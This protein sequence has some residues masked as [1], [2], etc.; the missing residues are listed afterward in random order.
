M[1]E[2]NERAQQAERQ[3]DGLAAAGDHDAAAEL[4]LS[5]LTHLARAALS[6]AN[7]FPKSRPELAGQLRLIGKDALAA[8]LE[9]ALAHRHE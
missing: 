4:Q 2:A 5:A 9:E 8:R 1:A 3:R 6:G 7:V